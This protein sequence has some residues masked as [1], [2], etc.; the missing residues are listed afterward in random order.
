M[1]NKKIEQKLDE[2]SVR[3]SKIE[4]RLDRSEIKKSTGT[5]R[6][7]RAKKPT[8]ENSTIASDLNNLM[9]E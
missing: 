4:E 6:A 8:E 7:S 3:L 2:I 9:N 5:A 1:N